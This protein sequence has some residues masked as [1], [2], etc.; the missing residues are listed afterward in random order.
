MKKKGKHSDGQEQKIKI[1]LEYGCE[2]EMTRVTEEYKVLTK[3][4]IE[5]HSLNG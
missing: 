5:R 3:A 1:M 4:P 2:A